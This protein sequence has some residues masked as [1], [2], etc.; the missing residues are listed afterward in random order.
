[1]LSRRRTAVAVLMSGC[2]PA[3]TGG[4]ATDADPPTPPPAATTTPAP[5]RAEQ[6]WSLDLPII[7][8]PVAAGNV[9][10][11]YSTAGGD[12]FLNG[13]DAAT[14]RTLWTRP[15]HPGEVVTGIAITPE[16]VDGPDGGP[17]VPYLRP[18]T[19]PGRLRA[20]LAVAD[21]V[22]GADVAATGTLLI[23][24]PPDAC[25]DGR[26]VCLRARDTPDEYY[27]RRRL[28]LD[29]G[30]L[31]T[32]PEP[33]PGFDARDI[34][35]ELS[36]VTDEQ[37]QYLAR[38]DSTGL[39]WKQPIEDLFGPGY[40]FN[41]GWGFGL[42]P[43]QRL[44][45]GHVGLDNG[46]PPGGE[47][48]DVDL[49]Q[50]RTAGIDLDTGKLRWREDGTL[51]YCGYSLPGQLE[52]DTGGGPYPVRCRY[53]G[54]L[55]YQ[56]DSEDGPTP[57]DVTVTV[58][59][60]D[61]ST[62]ETTWTLPMGEELR[63]YFTGGIGAVAGPGQILL[64]TPEGPRIVDVVDGTTQLAEEGGVFGCTTEDVVF[65]FNEPYYTQGQVLTERRGGP[66]TFACDAAGT[67]TN[68]PLPASVIQAV[69]LLVGDTY[70]VA[71]DGRLIGYQLTT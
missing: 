15:A 27:E 30:R 45:V 71:M 28:R 58:E 60:Y 23:G 50:E 5:P 42:R 13:V 26:D 8:D 14:G 21:P 44:Y 38:I 68:E 3:C 31:V 57:L 62:G 64:P 9:A 12:L 56:P 55:R 6:V 29:D 46:E 2:L 4:T 67:A 53:T 59:G 32:E 43:E 20:E 22:S 69:G 19:P 63:L 36:I 10:V 49:T 37:R 25:L 66:L 70:I 61:F 34:G 33:A 7:G 51:S 18:A 52:E 65:D 24:S 35:D 47:P 54:T 40:S 41:G 11:V 17:L 39:L 1:M 48:I 16:V